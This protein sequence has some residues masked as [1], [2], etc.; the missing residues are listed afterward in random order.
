M[1][2]NV[3][4]TKS[5]IITDPDEA[6]KQLAGTYGSE[7][8]V[9]LIVAGRDVCFL[10]NITK[11][12]TDLYRS[13]FYIKDSSALRSFKLEGNA[14]SVGMCSLLYALDSICLGVMPWP[15]IIADALDIEL[16]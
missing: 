12:E 13:P 9:D 5:V 11:N 3:K 10:P 6:I 4:T 15:E 8:S 14:F 16:T 1:A 2:P 7:Y